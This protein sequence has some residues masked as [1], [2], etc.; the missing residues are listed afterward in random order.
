MTIT[1][2][3]WESLIWGPKGA[4][5]LDCLDQLGEL[6][7]LH[8][9][10]QAVKAHPQVMLELQA[11]GQTV[12]VGAHEVLF[13]SHAARRLIWLGFLSS[14]GAKEQVELQEVQRIRQ[15]TGTDE[16]I[17]VS[18]VDHGHFAL[19]GVFQRQQLRVLQQCGLLPRPEGTSH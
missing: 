17:T 11:G 3:E 13:R 6:P 8:S 1:L 9:M 4:Q 7:D 12:D 14:L 15:V 16:D 5:V 2:Q 19:L 10:E 18:L